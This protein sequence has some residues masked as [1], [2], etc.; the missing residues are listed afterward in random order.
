MPIGKNAIKRVT[1][2]SSGAKEQAPAVESNE[3]I[4][5]P[6]EVVKEQSAPAKKKS[7][8]TKKKTATQAAPKAPSAPKKSMESEPELSPINTA[9]AV[10]K[11]SE[12]QRQGNGY[13]NIGGILPIYLL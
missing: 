2:S 8:T 10:I 3:A 11:S 1:T 7:S 9:K 6:S 5:E 12:P 13:V 4:K